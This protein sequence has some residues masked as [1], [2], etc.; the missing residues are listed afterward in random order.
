MRPT[1]GRSLEESRLSRL[2]ALLKIL[3]VV[4]VTSKSAIAA[5]ILENP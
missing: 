3:T 2:G 4:L 1:K 5:Q